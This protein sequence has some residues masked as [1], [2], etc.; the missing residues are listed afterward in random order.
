MFLFSCT[1]LASYDNDSL[2][3]LL[4]APDLRVDATDEVRSK[5]E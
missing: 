1:D 3:K 4:K 2:V 5:Q